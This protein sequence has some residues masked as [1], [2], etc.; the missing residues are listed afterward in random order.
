VVP[1]DRQARRDEGVTRVTAEIV[2]R[3]CGEQ[4]LL[5]DVADDLELSPRTLQRALARAGTDFTRLLLDARS[6]RAGTFLARG[7]RVQDAAAA[8]GYSSVSHFSAVLFPSWFCLTP[9]EFVRAYHLYRQ[10]LLMGVRSSGED[11][12]S[13]AHLMSRRIMDR[14]RNDTLT[15]SLEAMWP[16]ARDR[17]NVTAHQAAKRRQPIPR[18]S[19]ALAVA[20]SLSEAERQAQ[21]VEIGSTKPNPPSAHCR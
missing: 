5:A 16:P 2:S 7:G 18:D 1:D 3:R 20:R 19:H 9:T 12:W 4:I 10:G 15:E 21:G 8:C 13:L 17:F 14:D 6:R 11:P